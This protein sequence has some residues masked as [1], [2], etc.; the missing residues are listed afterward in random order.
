MADHNYTADS[1]KSLDWKEHIRLRPGMYIGKLGD[2]SSEDDGIYVLLKEVLDNCIDEFVM[3]F[4]KQIDVECDGQNVMVRDFGRGI[5]LEKLLDCS[6]KINTGAKYDSEAFKKSVGLNGVGIKAV[7]ALSTK[8]DIQSFREGETRRIEYAQGDPQSQD[9]KNKKTAEENGTVISYLPDEAMF[10]K[11]RYRNEYVERMLRYYTYLNKGLT[12]RYNGKRF[13]SKEGLK[14]LLNENLSEDTLYPIIHIEGH[15]IEVA[16]THVEQYGEDYFSFVNGQHTTQGGTHQAAFREALVKTI[17]DFTK[18]NFEATDIRGG[19]VAAISVKVQEPVFESQTKTKLGSLT[20]SPEG[21]TIR[22][23]V[24]NFLKEKLDNF[25]HKHPE[26]ADALQAKIQRSERERKELKGIQKIARERAKKSKVHNRK[27]RDCRVHLNTKDKNKFKSTLFITEGDSA[28]GSITKARDVQFQAVF[29]LKGKPLNSFGLTRKVVYE[30]EE[31]NLIQAAL[32]IEEDLEDLRYNQVVIATDADV[33]GMHIRLLLITFFL[34][35]FP[36]LIRQGHLFV[37]QTPLFRVRN[38]KS[39]LYCY[40]DTEREAAI[41]TLGKNPEITRFKGLGE[42]SPDEFKHFIS[43]DIRLDPVKIDAHESIKE[44]LKFFMGKNTPERQEYIIRNLRFEL[45][46]VEEDADKSEEETE[47]KISQ[48]K[49]E[50]TAVK[51]EAA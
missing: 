37:L 8:F 21:E 24:G 1:I 33:D 47:K 50:S 39:T 23:F 29:S 40:D 44:M 9:K 3:G 5:P 28:S 22:T 6:S 25:L 26:T 51:S 17:R 36:E 30:N 48:A 15:D 43:E 10:K 42:I 16:F 7:N 38:K 19:L 11:F 34:Q 31:F 4:G 49:E 41:K 12:I 2:G 46:L 20:V 45:D 35:F 13:R 18:K 27:L 32:G 14:D